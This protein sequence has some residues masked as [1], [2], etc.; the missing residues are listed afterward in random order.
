MYSLIDPFYDINDLGND[1]REIENTLK[2]YLDECI[3]EEKTYILKY[4]DS[5]AYLSS[6]ANDTQLYTF[7]IEKARKFNKDEIKK[8]KNIK[9]LEAVEYEKEKYLAAEE[10]YKIYVKA[11]CKQNNTDISP[12]DIKDFRRMEKTQFYLELQENYPN[13]KLLKEIV[14]MIYI[15][16][17]SKSFQKE[18]YD[19][20]CNKQMK[21][22]E[23]AFINKYISEELLDEI[24]QEDS[25]EI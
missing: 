6:Y 8:L 25:E 24:E 10:K 15:I 9:M 5:M 18:V 1:T 23:N 7:D 3:E 17:D 2:E 13:N 12:I 21:I 11:M 19:Y 22:L 20:D 14:R 4:K 16:N